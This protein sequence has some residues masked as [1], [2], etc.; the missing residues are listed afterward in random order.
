MSSYHKSVLLQETIDGLQIQKSKKYIDA[1]LGGAGHALE[2][3]KGGG[4][5]LG[6]DQDEDALA[7]VTNEIQRE[8]KEIEINRDIFLKQGNFNNLGQIAR[9]KGF[10]PVAGILFDLGVSSHQFDTKERGFSFQGNA[11]LDM[12]MDKSLS[13]TAAD[14]INGLTKGE[15][16]QLFERYGDEYLSKKIAQKIVEKRL[17]GPIQRT[18]DL[19]TLITGVYPRGMHKIH[20][21]TKVF[22]ALRIAV[23]DEIESLKNALPQSVALLETKGRLAVISFHSL[24]D[25]IVKQTFLDFEAQGLGKIIT[26]KPIMPSEKEIEENR[27]ARSS[28]LRIFEKI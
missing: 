24:E 15:L 13:V 23:N 14:L 4:I 18:L 27:R 1:T 22:Q 20:P 25:R 17:E 26:K 8:Y 21:A 5:V 10:D 7:F 9:E 16:M 2:I 3:V 11:P 12:R 19:A 6:I 28:K